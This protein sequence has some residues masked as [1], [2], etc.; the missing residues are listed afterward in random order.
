MNVRE[1][2]KVLADGHKVVDCEGDVWS[3]DDNLSLRVVG[4]SHVYTTADL[5]CNAPFKLRVEPATDEELIAE[6]E[7]LSAHSRARMNESAE[8]A[9]AYCARMLRTRKVKP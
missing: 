5:P 7:R 6:M 2:I 4:D 8:R 3:M 9:Y 1:A